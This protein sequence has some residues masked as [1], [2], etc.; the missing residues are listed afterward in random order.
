MGTRA[1][2]R[3]RLRPTPP[4]HPRAGRRALRPQAA[5]QT[6]PPSQRRDAVRWQRQGLAG[7]S[8]PS[9]PVP[10]DGFDQPPPPGLNSPVRQTA[11]EKIFNNKEF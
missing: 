4:G 3:P 2:G 6:P 1:L 5:Q 8:A 10:N 7:W 11:E 9:H